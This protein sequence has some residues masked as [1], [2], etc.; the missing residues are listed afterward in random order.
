[1]KHHTLVKVAHVLGLRWDA[2]Q[3]MLMEQDT[4]RGLTC[5]TV[6]INRS[7]HRSP[8]PLP[9]NTQHKILPSLI[10]TPPSKTAVLVASVSNSSSLLLS[11]F[12]HRPTLPLLIY[13]SIC[14]C[15]WMINTQ[16]VMPTPVCVCVCVCVCVRNVCV[17]LFWN[18]HTHSPSS[19]CIC[20]FFSHFLSSWMQHISCSYCIVCV[21]VC[22]CVCRC[23]SVYVGSKTWIYTRSVGLIIFLGTKSWTPQL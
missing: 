1:M 16:T 15:S 8:W 2:V 19:V 21:C 12:L 17:H 9:P 23:F 22:V 4:E 11:S 7:G 20:L 10:D 18:E 13:N 14:I 6:F 5:D 3:C